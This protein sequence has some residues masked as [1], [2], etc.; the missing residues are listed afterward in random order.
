[1]AVVMRGDAEPALMALL[2][3]VKTKVTNATT[4]QAPFGSHQSIG[5]AEQKHD[6]IGAQVRVMVNAIQRKAGV[7]V[8]PSSYL[9]PWLIRHAAFS[10]NRYHKR[11]DGTTPYHAC[12]GKNYIQAMAH[13]AECREGALQGA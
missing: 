2:D 9:F 5:T 6:S 10:I 1:M 11:R 12:F 8:K 3:A 13:F 4:Q 7:L